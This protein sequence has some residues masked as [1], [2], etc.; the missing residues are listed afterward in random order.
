MSKQSYICIRICNLDEVGNSTVHAP[1]HSIRSEG[2]NCVSSV[3][4]EDT[5]I[6]VT[7]IVAVN[8]IDN[9]ILPM[10][11]FPEPHVDTEAWS[12]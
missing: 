6:S 4:S 7:M 5:G 2:M 9:H 10:L 1:S 12:N 11:I 8:A 3:T